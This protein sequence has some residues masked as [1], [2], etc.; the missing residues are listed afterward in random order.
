MRR[1][2]AKVIKNL[3]D[4]V[5][6]INF[7]A[8]SLGNI[9]IR[10]YLASTIDGDGVRPDPRIQRI[11]MVGTPNHGAWMA[12]LVGRSTMFERIAG[13]SGREMGQEW[14]KLEQHLA[15]P[16]TEFGIIAGGK[17]DADG[18]NPL[19]PG[20]DDFIVAVEETKLP[21]ARDFLVVDGLH[22]LLL[23]NPQVQKATLQ[24]LQHGYFVT[25]EARHPLSDQKT[26][27]ANQDM[28]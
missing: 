14:T 7:V 27:T 20:D 10:R 6:E 28:R 15:I 25:E 11:V 24:F 17:H 9:V 4:Q 18:Y 13:Q 2:L 1:R 22:A 8:H 26:E 5:E 3:G 23:S 12:Q 21:G 19:L 16:K